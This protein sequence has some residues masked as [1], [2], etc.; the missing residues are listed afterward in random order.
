MLHLEVRKIL[1][2]A[3]I[4]CSFDYSCCSWYPGINET[5][6]KKLQIMQNK[7]IRFILKLD[8]RTHIGNNELVNAGFLNVSDR[9]KQL[10]LGHVFKIRNKTCPI[11]LTE[12][13]TKLNENTH[14]SE[15]RSKAYNFEVPRISTNTF[16]YSAI[17]DWNSLSNPI[18]DIKGEQSFKENV[19]K[20]LR[21]AA[22]NLE[23][24]EF[25]NFL[26]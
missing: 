7:M 6:K 8:N 11:Y 22:K 9:I 18:K 4:Q 21:T 26:M 20:F 2:T 13:F 16:A 5:F 14:R 17:K 1:C 10:K 23:N 25:I 24:S 12:N 15:T 19:K 3:L